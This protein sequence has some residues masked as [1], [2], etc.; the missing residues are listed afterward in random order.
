MACRCE[1]TNEYRYNQGY[2]YFTAGVPE[3]LKSLALTI[4]KLGYNAEYQKGVIVVSVKCGSDLLIALCGEHFNE[5]EKK[6][7]KFTFLPE[8]SVFD[9]GIFANLD[10][11]SNACGILGG[12]D[13]VDMMNNKSFKVYFQPI[14]DM[15]NESIYGYE[16]L[17]RGIGK[18]GEIIP[19]GKLF[20]MAK[21]SDLLLRLDRVARECSLEA[22][23]EKNIDKY[24][25]INFLPSSIYTPE[26]C[27][28]TTYNLAV[29]LN[30]NLE[31]IVFEV[32]ET[33]KVEDTGHLKSILTFYQKSGFRTAL[34]DIGSGY[35]SLSLLA[36]L[37]PDFV[38]VDREIIKDIHTSKLKQSILQALSDISSKNNILL[39]AEGV[40]KKEELEY[41]K[42]FNIRFVQGF[43]YAKPSPEPAIHLN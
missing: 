4:K 17:L 19:P 20:G 8:G 31:K 23:A 11:L 34:D 36:K 6:E 15:N 28:R 35:A 26:V 21:G 38:K 40:E 12:R 37:S 14:I 18:K 22:I 9:F 1:A 41:V 27:L 5:K 29:K 16:C 43:Y 30:L 7:I 33:E 25:F 2:M 32:S 39:L 42:S 10:T 13:L 24:C 3:I